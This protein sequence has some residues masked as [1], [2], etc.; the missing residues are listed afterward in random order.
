MADD[1]EKR[2]QA[3]TLA[4]EVGCDP[5]TALKWLNHNHV[6]RAMDIALGNAADKLDIVRPEPDAAAS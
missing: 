5:R 2:Q 4:G 3:F 1:N 6:S